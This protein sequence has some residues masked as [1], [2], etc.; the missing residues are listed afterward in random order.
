MPTNPRTIPTVRP[1]IHVLFILNFDR[2]NTEVFKNKIRNDAAHSAVFVQNTKTVSV[3]FAA[4]PRTKKASADC[5][6]KTLET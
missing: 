3:N 2:F 5:S 6:R 4:R 1:N